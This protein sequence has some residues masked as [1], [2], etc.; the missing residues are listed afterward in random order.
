MNIEIYRNADYREILEKQRRRF[1]AMVDRRRQNLPVEQEWLMVVEHR[2]VYTL[3]R[4][5]DADN[6]L[7]PDFL[8]SRGIDLVEV[9]R[10]GD[11][12]FHGPGQV[13]VYPLIDLAKRGS[14]VKGYVSMLEEAVIRTVAEWGVT[15]SRF[16][17]A[18]G[19]WVAT[20]RDGAPGVR[21]IAALGIKCSRFISMHGL[22]LNVTTD[23]SF[24][25]AINPCG[26]TDRPAT[27]LQSE[28]ETEAP[29][30]EAV[31]DRLLHHL[32]TLL[33]ITEQ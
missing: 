15:A 14:G 33:G 26:F 6:L 22:A 20:P 13:V 23:M 2:P 5:G 24:F 29:E 30:W 3:G 27:N 11:I 28:I 32:L 31:A 1:A 21:K 7:R 18:P 10:G 9:E 25:S 17:D 12:T 8:R 4:H 16:P 19:V